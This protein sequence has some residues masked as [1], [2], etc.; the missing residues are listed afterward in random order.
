MEEKDVNAF[1]QSNSKMPSLRISTPIPKISD[2]E[3]ERWRD[4][5]IGK[6]GD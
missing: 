3:T 1:H 2:G 4:G 6:W 5:G